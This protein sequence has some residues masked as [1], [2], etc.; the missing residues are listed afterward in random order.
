MHRFLV[1]HGNNSEAIQQSLER[2]P[3]WKVRSR[4]PQGAAVGG[5]FPGRADTRPKPARRP[6]LGLGLGRDHLNFP[7]GAECD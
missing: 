1:F 7:R 6:L 4:A 2:R 5:I 3:S